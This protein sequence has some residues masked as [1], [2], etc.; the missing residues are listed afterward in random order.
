MTF[1]FFNPSNLA[2]GKKITAAFQQLEQLRDKAEDHVDDV[3]N[4]LDVY[5]Q[6][7]NRNY[8]APQPTKG[9]MPARVADLFEILNHGNFIREFSYDKTTKTYKIDAILW[10]ETGS[11]YTVCKGTSE[12]KSEV[13]CYVQYANSSKYPEKEIKFSETENS[14]LGVLF[15]HFKDGYL[16]GKP[17]Q[18]PLL[19]AVS[20]DV[21]TWYDMTLGA[22]IGSTYQNNE[23]YTA[24]F[25]SADSHDG[26]QVYRFK[27]N[28][29]LL[30]QGAGHWKYTNQAHAILYLK[31]KDKLVVDRFVIG[32]KI[33]Y[34]AYDKGKIA[35][36]K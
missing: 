32:K 4:D 26:N 21:T 29:R 20:G 8:A 24:L 25:A 30:M 17:E 36:G 15:A 12:G 35:Y 14:S 11:R 28:D 9:D 2:F 27:V 18:Y 7:I 16:S 31:P 3:L 5:Q 1:D 33:N 23:D 10:N 6:F 19:N 22:N 34:L 13:Y